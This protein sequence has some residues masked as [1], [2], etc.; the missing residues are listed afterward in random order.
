LKGSAAA[1]PPR[2]GLKLGEQRIIFVGGKGGVG[3]TTTASALALRLAERGERCLL[4]STDPAHSLGDLFDRKLGDR[5]QLLAPNLWGM[6]IDP[7]GQVEKHLEGVMS[8]MRDLVKPELFPEIERQMALTRLSPGAVEAAMLERMAELMVEGTTRFDRVVFDTAPT[9]HTLRLLSL[10]EIMAAWTDGLLRQ[11]DR[12]DSWNRA[13]KKLNPRPG[14]GDDL[15]FMDAPPQPGDER[16]SRIRE[17]LLERRRKFYQARRVLLEPGTSAFIL[18]LIPEK[19]P[20]LESEKAIQAL[21]GFEVPVLGMVVN[22][23][24]PDE[25]LGDFLEQRREQEAAYLARIE[26]LFGKIHRVYVPL[27][28]RDVE[29][30][31]TLRSLADWLLPRA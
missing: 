8:T 1:S 23:V 12:S 2:G 4:V 18:V 13:L 15:A 27:L 10:P 19:L 17:L 25:P 29:G 30:I 31:D 22:R 26:S 5:E 11:R 7:E 24:L 14:V 6:E 3:K 20:I 9:G 21:A 16:S 28:P